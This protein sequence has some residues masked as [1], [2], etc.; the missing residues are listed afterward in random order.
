MDAYLLQ[1]PLASLPDYR[2]WQAGQLLYV[3]G[4]TAE[5]YHI[6]TAGGLIRDG[7]SLYMLIVQ[8]V[9]LLGWCACGSSSSSS[10]SAKHHTRC[11]PITKPIQY[12]QDLTAQEPVGQIGKVVHYSTEQGYGL[13]KVSSQWFR[14]DEEAV[15]QA[16]VPLDML[17]QYVDEPEMMDLVEFSTA[18]G[19][20]VTGVVAESQPFCAASAGSS[21]GSRRKVHGLVV[22][23]SSYP[24]RP[25][26]CGIW[27]RRTVAAERPL[28][29]GHVIGFSSE[30]ADYSMIV[31]PFDRF[32][33]DL[34][35]T[36]RRKAFNMA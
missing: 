5:E 2:Y 10:S 3:Q 22:N 21:S 29:L 25:E 4:A 28:L 15:S 20:E 12:Y 34:K 13:V 17:D 7:K 18:S 19:E 27:V 30:G 11:V 8:D 26:D 6:V 23:T 1:S 31:L 35:K 14:G 33:E 32:K 16:A 24:V 36:I 9:S